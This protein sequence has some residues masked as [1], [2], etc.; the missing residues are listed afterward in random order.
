MRTLLEPL[1]AP[2]RLPDAH[3]LD[4]FVIGVCL[5]GTVLAG[6][7]WLADPRGPGQLA[8]HRELLLLSVLLVLGELWPIPVSRGDDSVAEITISSTFA[9]ALV[10]LGPLSLVLF[11]HR[12]RADRR[13]VRTR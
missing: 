1:R 13:A 4:L 10:V 7:V 11:V 3:T 5:V 12:R 8:D 9:V 6:L 2:L